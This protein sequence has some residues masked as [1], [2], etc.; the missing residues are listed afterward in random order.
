MNNQ[1]ELAYSFLADLRRF[2]GDTPS[3]ARITPMQWVQIAKDLGLPDAARNEAIRFLSANDFITFTPQAT[4]II[5]LNP[6][7]IEKADQLITQKPKLTDALPKTQEGIFAELDYWELHLN[8]GQPGSFY[9][10]QVQARIESLRHR[11]RRFQPLMSITNNAVGPNARITHGGVD[12]SANRV[13]QDPAE[14]VEFQAVSKPIVAPKVSS[15]KEGDHW[16]VYISHASEDKQYV[17]TLVEA[18]ESAGISVWY[19]MNVLQWG[20]PFAWR[21]QQGPKKLRLRDCRFVE[22]RS[23]ARRN[24]LSMNSMDFSLERNSARRS[25]FLSGMVWCVRTC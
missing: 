23:L 15:Q 11:E 9:W 22:K 3:S 8:D 24:G 21:D 20:R 6:S 7:G 25:Y 16:D 19:D 10:Q 2:A 5:A 13:S 14:T 17:E 4:Q 18:L 12:Y 1:K